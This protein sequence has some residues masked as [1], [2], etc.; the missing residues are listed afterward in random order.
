MML[1]ASNSS[2]SVF[3]TAAYEV[4]SSSV[5]TIRDAWS[6]GGL[7]GKLIRGGEISE[8]FMVPKQ[9]ARTGVI[10][11]KEDEKLPAVYKK[12]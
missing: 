8:V 7:L 3:S 2:T 10:D 9:S 4:N 1:T 6:G 12:S 11:D 5:H